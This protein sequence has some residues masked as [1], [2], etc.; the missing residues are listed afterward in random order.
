MRGWYALDDRKGLVKQNALIV[1]NERINL[2]LDSFPDF[3]ET[4][5]TKSKFVSETFKVGLDAEFIVR[6]G[7][8]EVETSRDGEI[9]LEDKG[10][11]GH[12]ALSTWAGVCDKESRL[13]GVED[14]LGGIH[15]LAYLQGGGP[16][17]ALATGYC[18]IAVAVVEHFVR[19]EC[20][21]KAKE[22]EFDAANIDTASGSLVENVEVIDGVRARTE[23]LDDDYILTGTPDGIHG[24]AQFDLAR[25][26]KW[27][28]G[29]QRDVD[30]RAD[31]S[32][33]IL[34]RQEVCALGAWDERRIHREVTQ[35]PVIDA[36]Q[37]CCL[38]QRR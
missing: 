15:E 11:L 31:V 33:A 24:D 20:T 13:G 7:V 8:S 30:G 14:A 38:C 32:W 29:Q 23:L 12:D 18:G 36:V 26:E 27:E 22:A 34:S 17:C 21:A 37:T 16:H 35:G 1:V 4:F 6:R 10:Q 19:Y 5:F 25:Q 3:V 2:A 9:S 28:L